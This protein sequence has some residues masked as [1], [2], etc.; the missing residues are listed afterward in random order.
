MLECDLIWK[1]ADNVNQFLLTVDKTVAVYITEN[2]LL[3]VIIAE[4]FIARVS[5][6][7]CGSGSQGVL[8]TCLRCDVIHYVC[9]ITSQFSKQLNSQVH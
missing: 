7:E 4:V 5:G 2:L 1:W 9:S 8:F 3:S 6:R